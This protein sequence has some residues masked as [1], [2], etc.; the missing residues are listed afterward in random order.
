[1]FNDGTQ[2]YS[3]VLTRGSCLFDVSTWLYF[4]HNKDCSHIFFLQ[5]KIQF[6]HRYTNGNKSF[7]FK[8][9]VNRVIYA[10]GLCFVKIMSC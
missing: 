6:W 3:V 8:Q 7:E 2:C 1:M 9:T 4:N 10:A 5:P